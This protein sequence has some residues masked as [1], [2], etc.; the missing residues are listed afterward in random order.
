[1]LVA[2]RPL[3]ALTFFFRLLC[4]S[5]LRGELQDKRQPESVAAP[6]VA[7]RVDA[8]AS[9]TAVVGGVEPRAAAH[10]TARAGRRP[11]RIV[12]GAALIII[13]SEPIT[14]PFPNIAAH[15]VNTQ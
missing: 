14:A 5:L 6:I 11:L 15:V 7:R 12:Q 8:A 9:Y 13:A 3:T 4:F 2:V 10:N 1:M